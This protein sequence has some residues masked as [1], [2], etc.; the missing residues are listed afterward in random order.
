MDFTKHELYILMETI[1]EVEDLYCGQIEEMKSYNSS[2]IDSGGC[3][4]EDIRDNIDRIRY[5]EGRIQFLDEIMEKIY[6][7]AM[8]D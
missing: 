1:E 4:G 7:E 5:L 3:D 6:Q 2:I 8:K